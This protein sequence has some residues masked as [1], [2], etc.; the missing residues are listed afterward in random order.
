MKIRVALISVCLAFAAMTPRSF[1]RGEAGVYQFDFFGEPVS[2]TVAPTAVIDFTDSLS[3]AS[4]QHFYQSL[5]ASAFDNIIA[6]LQAYRQKHNPDDWL[7][8]QLIRKTA[9]Q[10]SPK[11]SNYN[12]YTLYKWYLLTRSG[13][14]AILTI[15][16]DKILFYVQSD[17]HIYNIPTG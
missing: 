4:I 15:A 2:F 7:F 8:Y 6:S 9:Q 5:N 3:I 10:I 17:E 13:F 16:A 12:R 14:G 11:S 1:A